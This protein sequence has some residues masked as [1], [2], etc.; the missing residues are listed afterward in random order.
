MKEV[1]S[2]RRKVHEADRGAD[3]DAGGGGP[4][5]PGGTDGGPR[6]RRGS[7][8]SSKSSAGEKE[9]K[10]RALAD[11]W[12]HRRREVGGLWDISIRNSG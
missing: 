2:A 1:S 7:R 12:A 5:R 4:G 9:A 3:E 6:G 8:R 11:L 10:R